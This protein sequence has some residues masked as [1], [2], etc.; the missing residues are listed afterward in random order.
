MFFSHSRNWV[1]QE[2]WFKWDF[3]I[4]NFFLVV[5]PSSK[6]LFDYKLYVKKNIKKIIILNPYLINHEQLWKLFSPFTK[7]LRKK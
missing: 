7:L 6:I 1:H 5:M 2:A 3:W 4:Y